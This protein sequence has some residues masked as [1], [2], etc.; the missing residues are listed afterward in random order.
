M[1]LTAGQA[2]PYKD[3]SIALTTTAKNFITDAADFGFTALEVQAADVV[4]ITVF[5]NNLRYTYTG[6]T[7]TAG[8]GHLG[9]SG[10][11]VFFR[12]KEQIKKASI[13]SETGTCDLWVTLLTFGIPVIS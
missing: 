1:A 6:T 5:T 11:D 7:V 12:G 4:H 3:G 10:T 8:T 2:N 13:I 9:V